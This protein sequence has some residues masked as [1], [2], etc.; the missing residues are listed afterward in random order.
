MRGLE[1][2]GA[3]FSCI[4]PIQSLEWPGLDYPFHQDYT[5][6]FSIRTRTYG[7]DQ[8]ARPR[9]FWSLRE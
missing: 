5:E 9:L 3:I 2:A 6:D 8:L 4:S 1:I 7:L